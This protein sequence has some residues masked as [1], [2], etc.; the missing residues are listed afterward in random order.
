MLSGVSSMTS[1]PKCCTAGRI[2]A[3]SPASMM[4]AAV[5]LIDSVARRA[6]SGWAIVARKF[7]RRVGEFGGKSCMRWRRCR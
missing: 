1:K 4:F 2:F 5:G 6:S 3:L 7:L